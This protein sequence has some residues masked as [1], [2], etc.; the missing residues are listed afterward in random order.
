MFRPITKM[1]SKISYT[2][3]LLFLLLVSISAFAQ[4]EAD[5]PR[6][7]KILREFDDGRGNIIREV[8][9]KQGNIRVTEQIILP[10]V[11]TGI[12]IKVPFNID[13]MNKDSLYVVVDKSKYCV[14]LCYRK[15]IIK[16]YKAVFGPNPKANKC[17]EGDRCTPEGWF[18]I[19]NKNPNSKYNKFMLISYPNDSAIAR[20]NKMKEKGLIPKSARIGGDIGIHGIWQGGDDLI[21]MG[22]GW[23]DGCIALKNVDIED[24]YK[25][26]KIGTRVYIKK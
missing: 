4:K 23:T 12:G 17:M 9:Y 21:E 22:V 20:F 6:D 25:F 10:K 19:A 1:K 15:K 11:Y 18:K 14:Q 8:Q 26:I 16:A 5:R 3:I 13:T 24:L 2:I 7:L